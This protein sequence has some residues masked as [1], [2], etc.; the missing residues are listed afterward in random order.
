MEWQ[1]LNKLYKYK[2]EFIILAMGRAGNDR[3]I[4][5]PVAHPN[6]EGFSSIRYVLVELKFKKFSEN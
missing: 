1:L 3:F 5:F 6:S 4:F 2:R